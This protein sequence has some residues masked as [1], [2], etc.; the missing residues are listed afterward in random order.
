MD[1]P[2]ENLVLGVG[3]AGSRA[4]YYLYQRGALK[5]VRIVAVDSDAEEL[6]ML[7]TLQRIQV[8]AP[9]AVP[10]GAQAEQAREALK[11]NLEKLLPQAR[12]LVVVVSLGGATGEFYTQAA[13]QCAQTANVPA[14]TFAA[15]PHAFDSE[16][17]RNSAAST[18]EVFR[19]QHFD[20]LALDCAKF[21]AFFPDNTQENAYIQAVRW[22]AN[23][24]IGYMTLFTHPVEEG[25]PAPAEP[26]GRKKTMKFDEMPRGIFTGIYP[27]IVDQQ[28][29]DVPTFLRLKQDNSSEQ[30]TEEITE[31]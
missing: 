15:L 31:P 2:T 7:P 9:P 22:I 10:V 4:A 6:S 14:V 27:T 24:V 29:L 1:I 21:G 11:E 13:L 23:T 5:N 8:P 17:L 30:K 19:A 20:V 3:T 25:N 26:S 12:M 28:N 18:L 16:E